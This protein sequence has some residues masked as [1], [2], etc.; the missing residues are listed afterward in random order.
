MRPYTAVDTSD[1]YTLRHHAVLDRD[2]T[3][4]DAVNFELGR[5]Y[6]RSKVEKEYGLGDCQKCGC[7]LTVADS[8]AGK[9]TQCGERIESD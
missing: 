3:A 9:C 6:V 7:V 1:L 5:R 4:V 8:E 2:Y